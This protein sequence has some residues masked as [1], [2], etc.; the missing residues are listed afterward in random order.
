MLL[1][2]E[3]SSHS[4]LLMQL[5]LLRR[6]SPTKGG[7]MIDSSHFKGVYILSREAD[8][9][10]AKMNLLTKRM[11]DL[12]NEKTARPPRLKLWILA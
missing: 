9:L 5:S 10:N 7:V 12:S 2:E 1:L 11:D 3:L 4:L 8:M 6:W